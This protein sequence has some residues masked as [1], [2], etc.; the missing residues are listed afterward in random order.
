M[1]TFPT[2]L[3]EIGP[4]GIGVIVIQPSDDAFG[5]VNFTSS[6][7]SKSVLEGRRVDLELWRLGGLLGDI[8]IGW[9]VQNPGGDLTPSSGIV[10]MRAGQRSATF[11]I[12]ARNDLVSTM[13]AIG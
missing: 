12:D 6:S 1:F 7:L 5:V 3:A 11:S 10:L 4:G 2:I 9:E 8:L 13:L